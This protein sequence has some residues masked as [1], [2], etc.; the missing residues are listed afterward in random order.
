MEGERWEG[1]LFGLMMSPPLSVRRC[2]EEGWQV[3]DACQR[4]EMR[5]I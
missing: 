1:L 2:D 4:L 5:C 3:V